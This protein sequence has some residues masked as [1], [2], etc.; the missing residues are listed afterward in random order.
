MAIIT[1]GITTHSNYYKKNTGYH[2]SSLAF[3]AV[4]FFLILRHLE[5]QLQLK[6]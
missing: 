4:C 2:G 1:L 3:V 6:L 5:W